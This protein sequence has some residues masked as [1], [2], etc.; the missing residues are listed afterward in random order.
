MITGFLFT[1]GALIAV[2]LFPMLFMREF[3]VLVRNIL[4]GLLLLTSILWIVAGTMGTQMQAP[5]SS[6][7]LT[8]GA[9]GLLISTCGLWRLLRH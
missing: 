4:L 5:Y 8:A 6:G 2:Y 3:W 9:I 1:F 7:W